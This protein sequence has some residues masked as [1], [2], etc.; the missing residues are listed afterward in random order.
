MN[1]RRRTRR[2]IYGNYAKLLIVKSKAIIPTEEELKKIPE[3]EA[4]K[5]SG[6][7]NIIKIRQSCVAKR[8]TYNNKNQKLT[9]WI[10]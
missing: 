5:A 4:Q 2:D 7:K 3:Q 10:S 6:N 8:V 1:V 9:S